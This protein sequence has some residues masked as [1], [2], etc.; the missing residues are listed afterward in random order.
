MT[1]FPTNWDVNRYKADYESDEHWELRKTFIETHKDKFPEDEIVC[2]AQVFTNIEFLGC[3]Y[4]SKTMERVA[5]LSKDVA[6]KFRQ[7]RDGKLKRTF[8]GASDAASAKAKG[9]KRKNCQYFMSP[10][11]LKLCDDFEFNLI[12]HLFLYFSLGRGSQ[13]QAAKPI[14]QNLGKRQAIPSLLSSFKKQESTTD[15]ESA[16]NTNSENISGKRK[17]VQQSDDED[18]DNGDL[19]RPSFSMN[20]TCTKPSET[21][22]FSQPPP[23]PP[24]TVKTKPTTRV[25]DTGF[26]IYETLAGVGQGS[27]NILQTSGAKQGATVKTDHEPSTEIPNTLQCVVRING[28]IYAT[29]QNTCGKKEAKSQALDKALEYARKVHYTIKVNTI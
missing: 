7:S 14:N 19:S 29:V 4:P 6:A 15:D 11:I 10:T 17:R 16:N 20:P 8:V 9:R 25:P 26:I 22:Y 3:R 12:E 5:L 27:G 18:D 13:S 28:K 1:S 24:V 21:K 2:L 23:S